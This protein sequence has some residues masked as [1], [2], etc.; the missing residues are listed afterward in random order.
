VAL[1]VIEREIESALK[2]HHSYTYSDNRLSR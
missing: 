1:R 2:V